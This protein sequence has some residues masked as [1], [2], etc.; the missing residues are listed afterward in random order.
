MKIKKTA[1]R[2]FVLSQA[3]L[4]ALG[5]VACSGRVV[6]GGEGI[7]ETKT[8]FYVSAYDAGYGQMWLQMYKEKFEALYEKYSFEDDKEGVQVIIDWN[9]GQGQNLIAQMNGAETQVYFNHVDYYDLVSSGNALDLTEILNENLTEF[10]ESDKNVM[11]KIPQ[12]IQEY[13]KSVNGKVYAI[14]SA[15]TWNGIQYNIDLFENEDYGGFYFASEYD[16]ETPVFTTGLEGDR[17]KAK[18]PDNQPDTYD[19]GLPATMKQFYQLLDRM[20]QRGVTPFTFTESLG[21]AEMLPWALFVNFQGKTE[22]DI[23]FSF[24]GTAN[25][26]IDVDKSGKITPIGP[27]E[28]N[29][30]NAYMLMKQ[31]GFYQALDVVET[32]VH[33]DGASYFSSDAFSGDQNHIAAQEEYL[34]SEIF[35]ANDPT[36]KPIAFLVEGTYWQAEAVGIFEDIEGKY[37]IGDQ[38]SIEKRR[39]GVMPLPHY[40]ETRVGEKNTIFAGTLNC[41]ARGGQKGAQL[42]VTKKFLQFINTDRLI[43]DYVKSAGYLRGVN[44]EFTEDDIKELTPYAQNLLT[45][46][47]NSDVLHPVSTN[48]VWVSNATGATQW[49]TRKN[50]WLFVMNGSNLSPVT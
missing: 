41:F 29:D 14:P 24:R 8:Q 34:Y 31:K 6:E 17:A 50:G 35:A 12:D 36:Q 39:F 22:L 37:G 4:L 32:L 9:Q 27:T 40:D 26:L 13:F 48:P 2:F 3:V 18:G 21:Y 1:K 44:V 15:E 19:D 30:E 38:Y 45:V 28:I 16:A 25:S 20:L 47:K 46:K 7:D 10:G 43:L 42:E 11:G 5:G 23:N 49:Q 33:K